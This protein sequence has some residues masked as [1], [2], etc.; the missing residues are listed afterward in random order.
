MEAGYAGET[1]KHLNRMQVSLQLLFMSD[2]LTVS[3]NKVSKEILSHRPQGDAWSSMRWPNEHP[4][5]SNF[6]LW[7]STMLSICPSQSNGSRAGKF[8][9]PTHKIW[10]WYWC[11]TESTLHRVH[12]NGETEGVFA[13]GQKPNRFHYSHSQEQRNHHMICLVQS[14]L[15]GEHWRLLSTAPSTKPTTAPSS[16][17]DVLQSWE[18]TWLWEHL[19]VLGRVEWLKDLIS[20]GTLVA[21]TEGLYIRELFPNLC[22]ASFVLECSKGRGRAFGSFLEALLVANAYRGEL[23]GLM[24]IHLILLSINKIWHNLTG[25]MEIVLDCLGVLQRV[26][27][28]PPYC[29][30]SR[31][32]HSDILKT[33]LVHCKGLFFTTYYLHIKEHQDDNASFDKLS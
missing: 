28:L 19:S 13:S 4:T 22:L 27:F 3:G 14:T 32:R 21:I 2:I 30:P 7:Q 8:I 12:N 33:I 11:K 24:A 17:L 9:D 23:F 29:I 5:G 26:T 15:E 18:N 1:L 25:S 31:C 16:F 20:D 6:Q 10:Q